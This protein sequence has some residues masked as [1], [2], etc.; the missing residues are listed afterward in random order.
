MYTS[1]LLFLGFIFLAV[2]FTAINIVKF[3]RNDE[4]PASNFILMT[5]G[6][7]GVLAYYL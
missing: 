6:I 7:V 4:I 2:W 5:I 3:F 1:K